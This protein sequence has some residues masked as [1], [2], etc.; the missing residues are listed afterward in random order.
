MVRECAER[1]NLPRLHCRIAASVESLAKKRWIVSSIQW[2]IYSAA[3]LAVVWDAVPSQKRS[4]T[5]QYPNISC[6]S[7]QGR[8][9]NPVPFP[10]WRMVVMGCG[11]CVAQVK[12]FFLAAASGFLTVTVPNLSWKMIDLENWTQK[13]R[14]S[15]SWWDRGQHHWRTDRAKTCVV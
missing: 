13:L 14:S 12:S 15:G 9:K 8:D 5:F 4:C 10:P 1:K 6:W 7:S 11:C 2:A 3:N